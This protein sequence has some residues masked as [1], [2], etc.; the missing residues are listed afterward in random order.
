MENTHSAVRV[1]YTVWS[2]NSEGVVGT[3]RGLTTAPSFNWWEELRCREEL[4]YSST[5]SVFDWT[6]IS[7]K[8]ERWGRRRAR[9]CLVGEV[10]E[11]GQLH[12][13]D[14]A[15][16]VFVGAGGRE[17]LS[18]LWSSPSRLW[19]SIKPPWAQLRV[20]M[21]RGRRTVVAL[22]VLTIPTRQGSCYLRREHR[23]DQQGAL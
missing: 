23:S 19:C 13:F 14:V 10:F 20:W 1:A 12:K 4:L 18:K 11:I 2:T 15:D 6:L 8:T 7:C 5:P 21:K 22:P 3:L 16:Q 17:R 9:P